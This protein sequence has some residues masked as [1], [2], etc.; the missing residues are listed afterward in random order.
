VTGGNVTARPSWWCRLKQRPPRGPGYKATVRLR[1]PT[2]SHGSHF[3]AT[4]LARNY[5]FVSTIVPVVAMPV[6][7][8]VKVNVL[9]ETQY[10]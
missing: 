9:P 8:G 5:C 7:S 10:W 3:A 2:G 1:L 6:V 4:M